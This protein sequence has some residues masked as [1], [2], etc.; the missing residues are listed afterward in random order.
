MCTLQERLSDREAAVQRLSGELADS[1]ASHADAARALQAMEAQ[2]AAP[3][4]AAGPESRPST[5]S[6]SRSPASAAQWPATPPQAAALAGLAAAGRGGAWGGSVAGSSGSD[7]S[8]NSDS[9]SFEFCR[10]PAASHAAPQGWSQ[11]PGEAHGQEGGGP[12]ELLQARRQADTLQFTLQ[13][14]TATLDV[15]GKWKVAWS[16]TGGSPALSH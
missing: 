5:A 14:C 6:S 4:P 16:C 2:L 3:V 9:G 7:V 13:V 10:A 8:G 11:Q 15:I 1:R 12:N